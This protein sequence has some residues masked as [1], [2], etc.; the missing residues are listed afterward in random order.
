MAKIAEDGIG[1]MLTE[2]EKR[3]ILASFPNR[4]GEESPSLPW[5]HQFQL[6]PRSPLP[7]AQTLTA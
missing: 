3:E 2:E 6:A 1:V 5:W 7:H 4:R